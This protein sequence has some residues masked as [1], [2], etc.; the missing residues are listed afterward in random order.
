MKDLIKKSN[1][2][3][4]NSKTKY[5]LGIQHVLAMFGAT[6]LVPSLTNMDPSIAIFTAGC[7]TLIFH[8]LTG[9]IV[10]VF[11]GSS[12]A[13]IGATAL[14]YESYGVGATKF[15]IISAGIVYLLMSLIIRVV[16]TEKVKSFFPPIV[17]GPIIM[18]IGLRLSGTAIEM[19][20]YHDGSIDLINALVAAVV[21]ITMI[22]VTVIGKSFFKL[23][24]ILI[25]IIVGY[26]F[27]F[28]IDL[29]TGSNLVNIQ[30]I[31]NASWL[32]FSDNSLKTILTLPEI[33]FE[34]VIALAPISV[35]VFMEH[36][37]DMT[38]NGAVVGKNF[39]DKPGIH[40]TIL[41]DGV[42]S[43]FAGLVGGPAN[44]TYG[45]NTG[46]LAVTKVYDPKILRIAAVYAIILSLVGKFGAVVANIPS[47]VMGGVSII[48][49][50]MIASIGI[51]TLAESKLDFTHSRNL[52][53]PSIIFVVGLGID[54]L[55]LF[56]MTT[57]SGLAI[58]AII[59]IVLNKVLPNTDFI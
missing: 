19:I 39:F 7:G 51:R 57:L 4:I 33:N 34:A 42:A 18:L 6:I 10:P 45:E 48:V 59:G 3:E 29:Y 31:V 43:L 52:L 49:F 53:I 47:P 22:L 35:V 41:A 20:G 27:S 16:G 36:I 25:A 40:R 11:I 24:P 26:L 58:A 46:V 38:T 8:F 1:G 2:Y 13:F 44:T 37:G 30:N 14:I 28:I 5:I 56:N 15:G 12:F 9:G 17:N 32:G 54:E 21:I 50:G 55:S 23:V